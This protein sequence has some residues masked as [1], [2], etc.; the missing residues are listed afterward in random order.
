MTE[1]ILVI[2][3]VSVWVIFFML[4]LRPIFSEQFAADNIEAFAGQGQAQM[5]AELGV[6]LLGSGDGKDD[7]EV[8]GGGL[9][10]VA[11]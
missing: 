7:G 8:G 9:G 11:F 10:M 5:A 6:D 4:A 2:G 1:Y 3:M